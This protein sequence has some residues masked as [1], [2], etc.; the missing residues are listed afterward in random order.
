MVSFNVN[1]LLNCNFSAKLGSKILDEPKPSNKSDIV[2]LKT[3]ADQIYAEYLNDSNVTYT[4]QLHKNIDSAGDKFKFNYYS[5]GSFYDGSDN[6]SEATELPLIR[7]FNTQSFR[8]FLKNDS[9]FQNLYEGFKNVATSPNNNNSIYDLSLK[10]DLSNI[11]TKEILSNNKLKFPLNYEI[12]KKGWAIKEDERTSNKNKIKDRIN[13]NLENKGTGKNDFARIVKIMSFILMRERGTLNAGMNGK[14]SEELMQREYGLI[15]WSII[16]TCSTGYKNTEKNLLKLLKLNSYVNM[17]NV[18]G[19]EGVDKDDKISKMYSD[20]NKTTQ[21]IEYFVLAFFAG[22]VNEEFEGV[23]NWSHL[24]GLSNY[25]SFHLP[26]DV[27]TADPDNNQNITIE[28]FIN[29]DLKQKIKSSDANKNTDTR[30]EI[31][32]GN[33]SVKL[34]DSIFIPQTSLGPTLTLDGDVIFTRSLYV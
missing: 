25:Q 31:S 24:N 33:L 17:D 32:I 15:C 23:T 4:N 2:F 9:N 29:T 5:A 11:V 18:I 8:N 1:T 34:T 6:I 21:N 22:W 20:R 30:K 19:Q 16:N 28:L 13:F 14:G 3:H 27:I 12:P 26:K 7:S 10:K